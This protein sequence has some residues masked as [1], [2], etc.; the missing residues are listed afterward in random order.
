MI[1]SETAFYVIAA[2]IL[3]VG[4]ILFIRDMRNL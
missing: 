3:L 4:T 2:L 1:L